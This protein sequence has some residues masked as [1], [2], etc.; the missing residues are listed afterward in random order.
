MEFV[1]MGYKSIKIKDQTY[2]NLIRLKGKF[3]DTLA[4]DVSIDQTLS[5]V[6]NLTLGEIERGH[7]AFNAEK[8][9]VHS[10]KD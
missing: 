6:V 3:T 4:R 9:L 7:I 1:E 8:M 5:E 2:N 10:S